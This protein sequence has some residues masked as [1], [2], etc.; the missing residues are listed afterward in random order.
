[1]IEGYIIH[2]LIMI[3]IYLIFALSLNLVL[4]YTGLLS[5]GHVAFSGLGA[6]T[7][8]ILTINGVPFLFAIILA[9][10]VPAI[11]GYLLVLATKKLRGD[12]LGLA[13][14]GFGFVIY[15]LFLNLDSITGGALGI[16]GI[17]KPFG[18]VQPWV[19][20]ILTI[21]ITT[22]SI[23][24]LTRVIKSP[25]GRLLQ[26]TRDEETNLR[27]LGKNTFNL[28]YKAMMIAAFFAGISGSLYANYMTYIDPSAFY[29]PGL[30]FILSVV[31]IGGLASIK[32]TIVATVLLLLIPEALRFL[33]VSTS[34][35]GPMRQIIYALV[36][37]LILIFR[38]RGIFGRVDLR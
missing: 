14:L 38:P 21:I 8:A 20:L 33:P 32:G 35:L 5:L 29:L 36:L 19:F 3:G 34:I 30:I 9:G 16:S 7:S 15:S 27:V 24:I 13:T 4:G 18:I 17:P 23:L 37:I 25:F 31:I 12:Y 2:L 1:M 26:A 22:I 28:K 10:I 6:Y 11:F